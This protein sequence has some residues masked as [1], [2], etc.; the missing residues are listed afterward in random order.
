MSS[1][2]IFYTYEGLSIIHKEAEQMLKLKPGGF[3]FDAQVTLNFKQGGEK[4]GK[5]SLDYGGRASPKNE[6]E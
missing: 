5:S 1:G 6:F 4:Y 3:S 2:T